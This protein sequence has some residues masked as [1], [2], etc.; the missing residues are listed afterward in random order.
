MGHSITQYTRDGVAVV[1]LNR[2]NVGNAIDLELARSLGDAID[3][4]S[5]DPNV[6]CVLLRGAG[7]RFCVGGDVAAM[8]AC[9]DR[10]A[11]IAELAVS[12]HRAMAGLASLEVPV[13]TAVHGAAA[14]AGLSFMLSGDVVLAAESARFLTAYSDVGLSPDCGMA[15]LLPRR[16]GV[17]NARLMLLEARRLTTA[18][19]LD[20]GLIDRVEPASSLN[21]AAFEVAQQLAAAPAPAT[22][23]TARLL[24]GDLIAFR[25]HLD[26]EAAAIARSAS[27]PAAASLIERFASRR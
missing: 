27:S 15:W 5:G 13:V 8:A 24:R 4:L 10:G 21:D 20:W 1:E 25:Q 2:P 26:G 23:L 11:F 22:G 18:E 14:G 3:Q 12:A 19:A 9:E 7:D 6:R 16:I 17:Q